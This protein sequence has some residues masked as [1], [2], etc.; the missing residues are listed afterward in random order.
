MA[1]QPSASDTA[2]RKA[3]KH[4]SAIDTL[5][6]SKSLFERRM[7]RQATGGEAAGDA[8]SGSLE[9]AQF[10]FS[11]LLTM[12]SRRHRTLLD[13]RL[14][15]TGQTQARWRTLLWTSLSGGKATQREIADLVGVEGPT[16]VRV[17]DGLEAQGLV[18]RS[19]ST[20][21]RRAKTV[22]LTEKAEPIMAEISNIAD[23][24]RSEMLQDIS[25][26]ELEQCL[27]V[28]ERILA[29]MDAA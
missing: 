20:Q 23:T 15:H 19:A 22:R 16:L 17:L 8:K 14:R 11:R 29:R 28:F 25:K 21:D 1:K 7:I 13:D 18:E 4:L 3:I 10:R 12:V 24:L 9:N 2:D 6:K 27:S 26:A 5:S